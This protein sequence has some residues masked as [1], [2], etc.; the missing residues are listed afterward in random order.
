MQGVL[1]EQEA[2]AENSWHFKEITVNSLWVG[3]YNLSRLDL[4]RFLLSGLDLSWTEAN[5][6]YYQ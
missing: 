6:P 4:G 5:T 1:S 3:L 2:A